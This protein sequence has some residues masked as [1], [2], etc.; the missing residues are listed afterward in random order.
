[1]KNNKVIENTSIP[2]GAMSYGEYVESTGGDPSAQLDQSIKKAEQ[3]FR[4]SVKAAASE[5]DREIGTYGQKAENAARAGLLH[6]GYSD[7]ISGEAY[8]ARQRSMDAARA[9]KQDSIDAAELAAEEA[10]RANRQGYLG[11]IENYKSQKKTDMTSAIQTVIGSGLSG[12]AADSYLSALGFSDDE[13]QQIL[14]TT[15]GIVAEQKNKATY[16]DRN[17]IYSEIINKGLT[18]ADAV[19]YAQYVGGLTEADAK[20]LA[21]LTDKQLSNVKNENVEGNRI[22]ALNAVISAGVSGEAAIALIKQYGFDDATA[23][24]ISKTAEGITAESNSKA[25]AAEI[26]EALSDILSLGTTGEKAEKYLASMYPGLSADDIA[27]VITLADDI[28]SSGGVNST[29]AEPAIKIDG[30]TY[31][32]Y[33]S[34]YDIAALANPAE[35]IFKVCE[36]AGINTPTF[37]GAGSLKAIKQ[38]LSGFP[39]H[40]A[41]IEGTDAFL[42]AIGRYYEGS[43]SDADITELLQSLT[44]ESEITYSKK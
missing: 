12:D 14:G 40:L 6:A 35:R 2:S 19:T 15:E 3:N 36:L 11:Y 4:D 22:N 27:T 30:D 9:T 26:R 20:T 44:G 41:A 18:G 29:G 5:Y 24:E 43:Y 21:A 16:A 28:Y 1:M 17:A 37:I 39:I 25:N 33:K 32:E 13:K 42:T 31:T 34:L 38:Q 8:V 23:A 7:Y 10:N